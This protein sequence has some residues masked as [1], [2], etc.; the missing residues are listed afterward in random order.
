[1]KGETLASISRISLN[2][3][4]ALDWWMEQGSH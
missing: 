1:M 4:I 3:L 2:L